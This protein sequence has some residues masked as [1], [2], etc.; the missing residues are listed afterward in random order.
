MG[1][2][3][4]LFSY[5]FSLQH[6]V[7]VTSITIGHIMSNQTNQTVDCKNYQTSIISPGQQSSSNIAGVVLSIINS[8]GFYSNKYIPNAI[9][10][11][12]YIHKSAD[13]MTLKKKTKTY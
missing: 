12:F 11:F 4:R 9:F 7:N 13:N 8:S 1:I 3:C 2:I 6:V 5:S 10:F